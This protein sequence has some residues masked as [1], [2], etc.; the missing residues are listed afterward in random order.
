MIPAKDII[1]CSSLKR[2]AVCV[3]AAIGSSQSQRH[4]L[5][6]TVALVD[7]KKHGSLAQFQQTCVCPL[8]ICEMLRTL[9]LVL[10][11]IW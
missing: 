7:L 5:N 3:H 9:L 4:T 1:A 6:N 10:Y 2:I 11:R 8:I